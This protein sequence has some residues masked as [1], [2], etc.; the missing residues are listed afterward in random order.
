GEIFNEGKKSLISDEFL[1]GFWD[2]DRLIPSVTVT[3]YFGPDEW[4]GP[5]SLFDMMEVK[6]PRILACMDNY[7]L[8]LI[9]PA[10]MSDEEIMKFQSSLREVLLFIKCSKNLENLNRILKDNEQRFREMERRAVDVIEVIT[11]TGL[12]YEESEEKIDVCE[13]IKEIRM[14][15]RRIGEQNGEK[16]GELKKAQESARN[17]YNLGVDIETIAKGVGY[18]VDVVKGWVGLS[19]DVQ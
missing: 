17:F 2:D 18:A 14:E 13:A 6:D 9:V 15:E 7:H 5:T 10:Q 16:R 19:P 4:T 1:S 3:I 8:R 11:N 12:K